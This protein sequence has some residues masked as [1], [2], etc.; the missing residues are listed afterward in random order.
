MESTSSYL[1]LADGA[2]LKLENKSILYL[3]IASPNFSKHN[4]YPFTPFVGYNGVMYIAAVQE[5]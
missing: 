2:T 1:L 5:Q 4:I 3:Q